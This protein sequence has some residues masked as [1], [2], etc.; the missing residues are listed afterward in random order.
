[1]TTTASETFDETF[2]EQVEPLRREIMAHCYRMMGSVH[3]AEDLVQEAYIR[4]WR[5]FRGFE[6]RSSVRTWM[7]QIA[8]NV[9]LTALE[10]KKRRPLPTG[11]GQPNADPNAALDQR[12]EVPWLEPMPDD[13]VWG[14]AGVDPSD[15]VISRDS[16]R[17][18]FV[19]ALQHLNP[20]Q[21]AVLILRDVL[22]W[23]ASEVAEL[24]ELTTA[25][26]NS[27]LQ[28]ARANMAK[29]DPEAKPELPDDERRRTLL[30]D[31]VA[32]FENYD[33][34]KIV[35]LLSQDAVWEMPPFLGWYQGAA[36]IG[37]LIKNYCPADGP[38]SQ[39]LLATWANGQPAFGLYMRDDEG[40]HRPFQMHQL[41]ITEEGVS[42]VVCY[43]DTD[44]FATFGLPEVWTPEAAAAS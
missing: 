30:K 36:D 32:A 17:L 18:A 33:V 39:R 13:L 21:R 15:D 5:A 12:T 1:M 22:A 25:G 24:L 14:G 3:D 6:G 27:T 4:A 20:Q 38:E 29:L 2:R 28:R 34:A 9:C 23:Q 41:T 37:T 16:V 31:Y 19:A 7:Y 8:T 10:S 40:V 26:V 35:S 44:L 11:L 42:H 43:F